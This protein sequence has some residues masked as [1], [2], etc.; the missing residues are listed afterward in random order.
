[1]TQQGQ[2]VARLKKSSKYNH[3]APLGAWF[4]VTFAHQYDDYCI[5]G[6]ENVYR[7]ADVVIG[8]R[9]PDGQIRQVS[10]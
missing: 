4:D 2:F 7:F 9:L 10:R 3:Q 1:M 5:K 6:N 8:V